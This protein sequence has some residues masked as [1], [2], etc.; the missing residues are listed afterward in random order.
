MKNKFISLSK[1]AAVSLALS[2]GALPA[3]AQVR[4]ALASTGAAASVAPALSAAMSPN[5]FAASNMALPSALSA[6]VGAPSIVLPAS[7]AEPS[8]V[9]AAASALPSSAAPDQEHTAAGVSSPGSARPDGRLGEAVQPE[10]FS[11]PTAAN[12]VEA[13]S[14]RMFDG[15]SA[16]ETAARS[17]PRVLLSEIAAAVRSLAKEQSQKNA[18][19]R[20]YYRRFSAV[21]GFLRLKW[22]NHDVS[23]WTGR[24]K[25]VKVVV[26]NKKAR[27]AALNIAEYHR[28]DES[29]YN[30][31][32]LEKLGFLYVEVRPT[33][34]ERAHALRDAVRESWLE[35]QAFLDS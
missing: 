20:D 17:T 27:T 26:D 33:M 19:K 23:P 14:A 9:A 35:F 3:S 11:H 1:S 7:A 30:L 4:A 13:D 25:F 34:L 29:Y 5:P 21:P 15:E 8:A 31:P 24:R 2:S 12:D 16:R 28:S 32:G 6:P 10:L 22:S 18:L